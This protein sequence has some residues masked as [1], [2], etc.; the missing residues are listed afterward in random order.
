MA[1]KSLKVTL[2]G[3]IYQKNNRW[4][5][6]VQLPGENKPKERALKL[7]GL[8]SATTDRKIAEEVAREMWQLAIAA[9][10]EKRVRAEA[11]AE[12]EQKAKSY[13][14]AIAKVQAEAD[15]TIAKI[16]AE[17]ANSVAQAKAEYE[18][19]LR[20]YTEAL[21]RAEEKAKVEAEERAKA[22]AKAQAEAKSRVEAEERARL[23][24]EM[25]AETEA[26]PKEVVAGPT[27]TA[28][29]ECCGKKDV[30]ENDLVRIDS[31]QLLCPDCLKRLSI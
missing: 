30:P 31:G 8:R 13:T 5:W 26:K 23:Q 9:E 4:W 20:V 28:T 1:K 7:A 19:K 14:E 2:P 25:R 3:D 12:A 24:A 15:E 17:A 18:E 22:E 11:K 29:C 27:R 16:K 21:A 10:A 6:K